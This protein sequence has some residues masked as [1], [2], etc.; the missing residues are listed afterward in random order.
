MS[1]P[2]APYSAHAGGSGPAPQGT[3]CPRDIRQNAVDA[4]FVELVSEGTQGQRRL[5][6]ARACLGFAVLPFALLFLDL[7]VLMTP[8][9]VG[10]DAARDTTLP[11]LE[12]SRPTV[13]V[14]DVSARLAD[15]AGLRVLI[16]YGRLVNDGPTPTALPALAIDLDGRPLMRMLEGA[17]WLASGEERPFA[18][19][20]AHAGGAIPQVRVSAAIG[21]EAVAALRP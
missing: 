14:R 6:R 12:R 2:R 8:R 11:N 20:F 21:Q 1:R 9:P 19:K 5:R 16:V 4:D 18:L 7:P 10:S 13:I 15:A 17:A 3:F